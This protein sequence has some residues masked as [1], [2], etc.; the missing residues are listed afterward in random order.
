LLLNERG[1]DRVKANPRPARLGLSILA[2]IAILLLVSL[3]F[4]TLF[5]YLTLPQLDILSTQL[6]DSLVQLDW[7]T[8][9]AEANPQFAAQ[10]E[11]AYRAVWQLI[12]LF[13]GFPSV[14]GF[15]WTALTA[16]V[17][18]FGGWLVYGTTAHLFARWLGG[19]STLR[20]FLGPLALAYAPLVLRGLS[21]FPGL[22][23]AA[24]LVFLLMLVA[25]FVAVRR[26]YELTPGASLVVTL[27]PYILGLVLSAVLLV[28]V[29]GFGLSRIPYLDPIL[30]LIQNWP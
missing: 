6:Y 21:H 30:R 14:A 2:Y 20:R 10:F 5:S 22:A 27:A 13:G 15:S 17:S 24:P 29:V 7:F 18:L 19:R 28:L 4:G 23:V 9:I 16:L 3:I 11:G 8:S 12:R 1:F 26:T 25:K